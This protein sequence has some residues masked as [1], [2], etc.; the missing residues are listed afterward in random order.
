MTEY[1]VDLYN[2]CKISVTK[3]GMTQGSVSS[4][5]FQLFLF[6]HNVCRV[7][8]QVQKDFIYFFLEFGLE[9]VDWPPQSPS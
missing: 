5:M 9:K 6:Q 7:Q 2:K 4:R 3:A 8:S 1:Q